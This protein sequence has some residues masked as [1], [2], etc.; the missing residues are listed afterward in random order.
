MSEELSKLLKVIDQKIEDIEEMRAIS[1]Y[2][3]GKLDAFREVRK[4]I[5]ESTRARKPRSMK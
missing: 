4:I 3:R 1:D 5:F 2:S